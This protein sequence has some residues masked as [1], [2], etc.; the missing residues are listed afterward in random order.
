MPL[1]TV[2]T[3]NLIAEA[4]K[5]AVQETRECKALEEISSEKTYES[6]WKKLKLNLKEQN[7][8]MLD[9]MQEVMNDRDKRIDDADFNEVQKECWKN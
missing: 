2:D 8:N 3:T 7:I 5:N 1:S 6:L 4:I 9:K